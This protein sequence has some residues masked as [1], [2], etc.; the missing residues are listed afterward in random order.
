MNFILFAIAFAAGTGISIQTAINSQ[1]AEAIGDRIAAALFSFAT[2]TV[3]LA[4][5][6]LCTGGLGAAAAALPAQPLW[7]LSGGIFGAG[8]MLAAVVLAPRIGL[9]NLL[10]LVLAG[11][12]VFSLAIDHFGLLGVIVRHVSPIKLAG[13]TIM[14]AG[15]LLTVFGDRLLATAAK[16]SP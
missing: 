11:Q 12:L 14:L 6:A 2:G 7:R 13:A 4:A 5:L 1:L 16:A 3:I 15:V 9:A 8:F 10:V